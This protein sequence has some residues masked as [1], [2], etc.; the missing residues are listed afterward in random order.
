MTIDITYVKSN[1][2]W[3]T[4]ITC[5]GDTSFSEAHGKT[6]ADP[7]SLL[8]FTPTKGKSIY[9]DMLVCIFK[10]M[11]NNN[12]NK[13]THSNQ[14]Y[15]YI[16]IY[17]Y[18]IIYIYISCLSFVSWLLS[19]YHHMWPRSKTSTQPLIAQRPFRHPSALYKK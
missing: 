17:T 9:D 16:Y 1:L 18:I 6:F 3:S 15:L 7:Y 4:L 5:E 10:N 19:P 14:I 12:N 2:P 8:F 11:Y 13:H